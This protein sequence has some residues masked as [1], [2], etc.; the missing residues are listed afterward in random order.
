MASHRSA[1]EIVKIHYDQ[2]KTQQIESNESSLGRV[3]NRQ[4]KPGNTIYGS[5]VL[6][7]DDCQT[8]KAPTNEPSAFETNSNTNSAVLNNEQAWQ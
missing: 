3:G 1:A 5:Y 4:Q 6:T 2:F 7:T 8:Q